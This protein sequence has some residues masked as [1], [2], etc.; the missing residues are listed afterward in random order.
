[1]TTN[2]KKIRSTKTAAKSTRLARAKSAISTVL[3]AFPKT[4]MA[5]RWLIRLLIV[6]L[7]ID[8]GYLIAIW[9]D[10]KWYAEGPVL[11]SAF[12]ENYE[13]ESWQ[14]PSLPRLRWSPV[15]WQKIPEN[16]IRAVLTAEDS[17]FFTHD[18]IDTEAFKSAME[19][20]W[21]QKRIVYGG[22]TISQQTVK[23][24]YLSASRNP[25]RKWHELLLTMAMEQNLKKSRILTL[26]LNV[27]EFGTGIFGIE[28]AARHYWGISAQNLTKK[29]AIELAAAL[30]APKRHNPRTRSKFFLKQKA[31]I[32]RNMG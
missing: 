32:T 29:Q 23:N 21:S 17:R 1:M 16:M 12:I 14:N 30:P 2:T 6:I 4:K 10:W 5:F 7:L 22:S 28:A 18:G 25:L 15:S 3:S 9:P 26:Y 20:N 8:I 24:F 31:K 27:A 19:Y 13:R 11:K